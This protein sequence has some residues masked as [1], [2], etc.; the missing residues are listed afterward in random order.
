MSL[1]PG[2]AVISAA[3]MTR[4]KV[5][6]G[7]PDYYTRA[8]DILDIGL[9]AQYNQLRKDGLSRKAALKLHLDAFSIVLPRSAML[10]IL[11]CKDEK[12]DGL[13]HELMTLMKSSMTGNVAFG[14]AAAKVDAGMYSCMQTPMAAHSAD[15][16]QLAVD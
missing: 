10:K 15:C 3:F 11:D 6:N 12:C 7:W 16:E 14:M 9:A 1:K 2:Y 4:V 13:E 8:N 5:D